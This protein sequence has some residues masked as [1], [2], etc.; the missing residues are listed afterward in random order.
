VWGKRPSNAQRVDDEVEEDTEFTSRGKEAKIKET[1]NEIKQAKV[2]QTSMKL[3][4]KPK[5][6]V[7]EDSEGETSGSELT[8]LSDSEHDSD[9]DPLNINASLIRLARF[10]EEELDKNYGWWGFGEVAE[11]KL[12]AEWLKYKAGVGEDKDK[13]QIPDEAEDGE[14]GGSSLDGFCKAITKFTDM[15]QWAD[16]MTPPK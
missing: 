13:Q 16:D 6:R 11:C 2:A 8:D 3:K 1:E 7:V 12:L 10:E 9:E 14:N 5:K 15:L 4:P